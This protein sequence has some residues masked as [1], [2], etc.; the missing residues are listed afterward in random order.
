ML[1]YLNKPEATAAAFRDLWLHT[2]D[3]ARRD[4]RGF[5]F[6]QG[7]NKDVI[8]RRG[9]NISAWE[10]EEILRSHPDVAEVAALA[11]PSEVGEDD[12]RVVLVANDG[13]TLD[14]AEVADLLRATDA[15]VHGAAVLRAARRAAAD[16][17]R[18]RREVQARRLAGRRRPRPGWRPRDARRRRAV[19]GA[20]SPA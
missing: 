4:E 15:G 8:R 1:G 7:R 16:A 9:Q 2:G 11:R 20:R 5:Y 19:R 12:L 13:A 10:V 6:Y 18:A 3:L 17:E 14:L